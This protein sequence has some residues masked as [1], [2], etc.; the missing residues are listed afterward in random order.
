MACAGRTR[1]RPETNRTCY[2]FAGRCRFDRELLFPMP[3]LA[4]RRSILVIHSRRW[5]PQPAPA[6][7][8]DL[9]QLTGGYCGADL[10]VCCAAGVQLCDLSS[11]FK[12]EGGSTL[13]LFI[14]PL[15][16][17]DTQCW[18]QKESLMLAYGTD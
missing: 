4:A 7:L 3:D 12:Q 1:V 6:L 8:D 10:R 5:A 11:L 2:L 18:P 16:R 14:R 17:T 9:A 15:C 13:L